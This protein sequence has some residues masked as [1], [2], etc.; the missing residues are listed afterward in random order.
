MLGAATSSYF[1]QQINRAPKRIE[2]RGRRS[3]MEIG[4]ERLNENKEPVLE[5][6]YEKQLKDIF[7]ILGHTHRRK[8]S[9]I[10]TTFFVVLVW[11]LVSFSIL[12]SAS[13]LKSSRAL[14]F[15]SLSVL[16]FSWDSA[17][18]ATRPSKSAMLLPKLT[19]QLSSSLLIVMMAMAE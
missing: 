10:P 1:D 9:T 8:K 2:W 11:N 17:R 18:A 4:K 3:R 7:A 14:I 5:K 15:F 12:G 6:A 19:G 16:Y 13:F